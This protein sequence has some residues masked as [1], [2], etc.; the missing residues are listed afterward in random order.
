M[1]AAGISA[2]DSLAIELR[3]AIHNGAA[4]AL[5]RLLDTNPGLANA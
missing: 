3:A 4:A 5:G 2:N 1:F